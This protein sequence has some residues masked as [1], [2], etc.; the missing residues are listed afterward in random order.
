VYNFWSEKGSKIISGTQVAIAGMDTYRP[1]IVDYCL[2]LLAAQFG[3]N[4]LR[5]RRYNA[6]IMLLKSAFWIRFS[7]GQNYSGLQADR[8]KDRDKKWN[9]RGD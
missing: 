5:F 6:V 1:D 7:S 9:G 3:L 2:S 4:S 8:V